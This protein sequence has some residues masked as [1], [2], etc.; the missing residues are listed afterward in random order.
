MNKIE[1]FNRFLV[2]F[3]RFFLV[4]T[5]SCESNCEDLLRRSYINYPQV[6]LH[7]ILP[8]EICTIISYYTSSLPIVHDFKRL[9]VLIII[10][11]IKTRPAKTFHSRCESIVLSDFRMVDIIVFVISGAVTLIFLVMQIA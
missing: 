5:W 7:C 8:H 6:K 3:Y 1:N 11:M 4:M 2:C 9:N 10:N